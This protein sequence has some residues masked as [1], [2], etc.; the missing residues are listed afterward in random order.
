MNE[1]ILAIIK[2]ARMDAEKEVVSENMMGIDFTEMMC[3]NKQSFR[4][5]KV[6]DENFGFSEMQF[7]KGEW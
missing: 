5:I 3:E 2:K 4:I 1:L 7:K 6:I